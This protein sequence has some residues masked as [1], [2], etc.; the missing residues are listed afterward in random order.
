MRSF[1]VLSLLALNGVLAFKTDVDHNNEMT[2]T[3]RADSGYKIEEFNDLVSPKFSEHY[4][5]F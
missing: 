5:A 3:Q 2:E 4:A 1:F